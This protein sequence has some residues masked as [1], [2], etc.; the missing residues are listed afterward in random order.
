MLRSGAGSAAMTWMSTPRRLAWSPIG[1]WTPCAPV[2][3]VERRMGVEHDLAVAVDRASAGAQQLVDVGLLDLVAAK[4]DLDIGDVADQPAGAVARPDVLDGHARHAL[5]QLDRLAHRELARRHVGDVAALDAAALALAGAEHGQPAVVVAACDHRADL[6]RADVERGDQRSVRSARPRLGS[7]LAARC[8]AGTIG[9]PGARGRRTIILP[10][11]RRSKRTIP[12]P[13]SPVDLSSLGE[14]GQRGPRAPL[15]FGKRDRLA[16]LEA[17]VP[18]AAADPGRRG[19]LRLRASGPPAISA[20]ELARSCALAP[21]PISSGRSGILSTGTRSSTTP[22]ASISASWPLVLPQRG[23]RAL[24]DVDDQRVG[25]PPRHARV[26]DPAE[27][28]A[29]ASRMA[30]TSTSAC[31]ALADPPRSAA[32]SQF[33]GDHGVD[34]LPVHVVE[35]DD[36]VAADGEAGAGRPPSPAARSALAG[37]SSATSDDDA[38]RRAG[39]RRRPSPASLLARAWSTGSLLAIFSGTATLAACAAWRAPRRTAADVRGA[40]CERL[41]DQPLDQLAVADAA[42]LRLLG[43]QAQRGHAGLGVD[44]EQIDARLALLVVPAEVGA[45]RALAAEQAVRLGGHVHH[46]PARCRPGPRAGQT[47]SVRPSVYLAS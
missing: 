47:C 42:Q 27:A 32:R 18:A 17:E 25:Q 10:G 9:S 16:R 12:R 43:N 2:D 15:A 36:L 30:A 35:A 8:G 40:H 33:V 11:T 24:D 4:L 37:M 26:L 5:G 39:S 6:R 21:G 34:Q 20:L 45:R 28:A 3:R 41:L 38:D 29:A 1:C 31:G 23:R 7:A 19:Q 13:S 46:R 44:L 14:F 22:S